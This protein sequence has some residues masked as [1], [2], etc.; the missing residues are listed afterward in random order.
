MAGAGLAEEQNGFLRRKEL[1]DRPLRV[2]N[3]GTR[4]E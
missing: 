3:G 2:A 4:A 1:L